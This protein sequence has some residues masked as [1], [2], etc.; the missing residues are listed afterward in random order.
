MHIWKELSRLESE[1]T[2]NPIR[3]Q[4]RVSPHRKGYTDGKSTHEKMLN[5]LTIRKTQMKPQ[6]YHWMCIRISKIKSSVNTKGRQ[7]YRY[8]TMYHSHIVDGWWLQPWNWKML[9][10]WKKRHDKPR[11]GIKEERDHFANKGPSSQSYGFPSGHVWMWELND[12]KAEHWRID[13]FE[14]WCWRRLLRVP[15]TE[16]GIKPVNPEGN[17]PW[18]FIGRTD[19]EA[20]SPTLWPPDKKNQL[21]G[22]TLM[23]GKIEGR[24]RRG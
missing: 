18:I 3:K 9:A 21:T 13:V 5:T 17:Q 24:R 6:D 2:N 7:G 23:L 4:Q 8:I 20:E 1:T 12:K 22:K 19:T 10:P 16:R 15:W 14:L 11:Q